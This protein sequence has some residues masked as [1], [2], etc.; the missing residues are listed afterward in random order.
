MDIIKDYCD[1]CFESYENE[2][3]SMFLFYFIIIMELHEFIEKP[4]TLLCKIM[5]VN[6]SDKGYLKYTTFYYDIFNDIRKCPLRI[7]ELGIGTNNVNIASN[8]GKNGRPGASLYGW[9]D[10]FY[11]SKIYGADIDTN[12]LFNNKKIKTFFCDQT[13]PTIIHDMWN[14]PELKDGFDI[15]IDDGLH[16]F[17]ANVCFFENSI[18]KLNPNGYYIIEDIKSYE[19]FLFDRAIRKWKRKYPN[20]SFT[21]LRMPSTTGIK[22]AVLVCIQRMY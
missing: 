19:I 7:F 16:Q 12:I 11:N 20:M 5:D 6:K 22:D 1:E 4:P 15:I 18:H 3:K 10:F 9:S 21:M 17:N 13:N 2:T 8:M 14:N